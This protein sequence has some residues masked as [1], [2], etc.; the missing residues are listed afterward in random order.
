MRRLLAVPRGGEMRVRNESR[1]DDSANPDDLSG[2]ALSLTTIMSKKEKPLH[3]L[4]AGTTA[5]AV[6]AFI[7][8][9]TEY[10]KTRSQFGGK[11]EPPLAIIRSTLQT[12]GIAGLYSGCTA[13]VETP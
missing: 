12:Q 5:G 13:L 4:I 1:D 3:S 2:S 7:T 10:V 6:E 8:Y 11:R 9:P